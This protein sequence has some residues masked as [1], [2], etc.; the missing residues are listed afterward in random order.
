MSVDKRWVYRC[1]APG[2]T[3]V[4]QAFVDQ[5]Q[6]IA[7]RDRVCHPDYRLAEVKV[8]RFD[9]T[10]CTYSGVTESGTWRPEHLAG[11]VHD[12]EMVGVSAW[13]TAVAR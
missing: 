6:E 7:D 8:A 9:C 2:C 10:V 1:Q 4:S 12:G 3:W 5:S 13:W 11:G